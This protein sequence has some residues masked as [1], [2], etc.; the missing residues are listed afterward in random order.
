[1]LT[2]SH[3]RSRVE[4]VIDEIRR[5]KQSEFP[6]EEPRQALDLLEKMFEDQRSVL[7]KISPDA[8]PTLSDNACS[9]SLYH[10]SIY[11][12][13]LGFILR[14]TNVRNAFETYAPLSRLA[15]NIFGEGYRLILSSEWAFS[16][17]FYQ[18]LPGLPGFVL[19]GLPAPESSN[20][21]LIPLAGHELGHAVWL[22]EGI[23]RRFENQI[24]TGVLLELT[25]K[26]WEEYLKLYPRSTKQDLIEGHMFARQTWAPA[27]DWARLQLEEIFCDIFGVRLFSE[28]YLNAFAYLIFPGMSSSRDVRYPDMHRRVLHIVQA[29]NSMGVSVPEGF[30]SAF[31]NDNPPMQAETALLVSIADTVS[32]SLV[33]DLIDLTNK[34]AH[35]KSVPERNPERVREI[36]DEFRSRVV[37]TPKKETLVD[38]L[39]A[40]WECREDETLWEKMDRIKPQDRHRILADLM[41]KSMEVA[42]FY[43]RVDRQP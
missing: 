38:I 10:L 30:E 21:L 40:G 4:A 25:E 29:A 26:R 2:V 41:L 12:P 1:M 7:N 18:F 14:S 16:P 34:L 31:V 17:H 3:A 23:S 5:L 24:E 39:N 22:V 13:L 15:Q 8:P 11:V 42:E 9:V 6:Y 20:P 36:C 43:E 35:A 28:S 37:P 32:A 33:L 19:I 27:C